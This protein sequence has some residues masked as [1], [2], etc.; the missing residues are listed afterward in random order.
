MSIASAMTR[1]DAH[2][3]LPLILPIYESHFLQLTTLVDTITPYSII[4]FVFIIWMLIE[5]VFYMYISFIVSPSLD[6][7]L[8]DSTPLFK[9]PKDVMKVVYRYYKI[10]GDTYPFQEFISKFCLLANYNEIYSQNYDSLLAFSLFMKPLNALTSEE[11]DT[12]DKLRDMASETFNI[13]WKNGHNSQVE[14]IKFNLEPVSYIHRPLALYGLLKFSEFCT[15]SKNLRLNG[16]TFH[17]LSKGICIIYSHLLTLLLI[18]LLRNIIL[19]TR[20]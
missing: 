6:S 14:H 7:Q 18:H 2:D 20:K 16:F 11:Y 5:L 19:D 17:K 15:N 4:F 9:H 8:G 12:I 3:L 13:K 1:F 10:L